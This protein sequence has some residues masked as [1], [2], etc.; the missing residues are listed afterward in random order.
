[1]NILIFNWRCWFHPQA[2]GAEKYL[3]E[4]SK[5]LIKAGHRVTWFVSKF[6]NAE[7]REII[8]RIEII[9]KGGKYSV[10][11][12]IPLYYL[13]QLR[14]RKFNI[15]IDDINGVPF[16]TPLF[17]RRPKVAIIHHIVGWWIFSKELPW[18]MAIIGWISERL[19]PFIYSKIK[20]ITVSNSSKKEME[21]F[22][23]RNIKI[24]P[25]G[26]DTNIYKSKQKKSRIPTI[27]FVGRLKKYKRL[28]LLLRA[29]KLVSKKNSRA[30]L[31][32]VGEGNV[33]KDLLK[34]VE[35]LN[36]KKVKFFGYVSDEKKI[37][38]LNKAW[39]FVT[40]SEKEGWAVTVIEANVCGTPVIAFNV[41]GLRDSVK[42]GFNGLL[43]K[44]NPKELADEIIKVLKDEKL[45]KELSRNAIKWAKR[46][47]W[48]KSADEFMKVVEDVV[49][50]K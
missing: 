39:V 28:D 3:Y 25:N 4:L 38:L 2:G 47:S 5:R 41:P 49:N 43:V 20:F 26:I 15:I 50:E 10:Y 9:R 19:I 45:R 16:F 23:I 1:M 48:D 36:L 24:V 6:N 18:F 7:T 8:D 14:K 21:R 32:I 46:F 31:W 11:I 13:F 35:R 42:N 37:T 29:F 34:L 12:Y 44:P 17:V 22:G 30:R 40:T 27:V 33:K